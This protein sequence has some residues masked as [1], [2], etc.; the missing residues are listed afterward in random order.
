[1]AESIKLYQAHLAASLA[2]GVPVA[3]ADQVAVDRS[4][5]TRILILAAGSPAFSLAYA[6]ACAMRQGERP[7]FRVWV[8]AVGVGVVT[9]LPAA[10]LFPWFVIGAI[11]WLGLMGHAVPAVMA[12]R[13]GPLDA[14]KRTAQ[15]AHAD[16][17]HAAG[18]FAT[19]AILFGVTR[20]GLGLLLASQA[21]A[22]IRVA[23]FIADV[24]VSPLLYLGAA[25][26]YV[27][28]AARVGLDAAAR[29]RIRDAALGRPAK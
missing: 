14:L 27:D 22:A 7:P 8:T 11:L 19:L 13:V 17:V 12:E 28:L 26:V 4:L 29:R 20:L 15:L 25:V 23:V 5:G 21:D 3:I 18:S 10:A 9:F 1:V 16:Y 24:V 2:L 6:A